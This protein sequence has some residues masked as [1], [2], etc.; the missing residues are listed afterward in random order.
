[1][2]GRSI[3]KV[4]DH[5]SRGY[6]H[7]DQCHSA[8]TLAFQSLQATPTSVKLRHQHYSGGIGGFLTWLCFSVVCL[9]PLTLWPLGPLP[10]LPL[11]PTLLGGTRM[12][13][14][15]RRRGAG[16]L[17]LP[18]PTHSSVSSL[19]LGLAHIQLTGAA[20]TDIPCAPV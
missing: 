8:D 18:T 10:A 14:I 11:L 15:L 1:M 2:K 20:G 4:E 13:I 9:P 17:I 5:C 3:K 6:L 19:A 12:V 16:H 7:G